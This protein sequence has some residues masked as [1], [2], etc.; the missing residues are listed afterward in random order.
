MPARLI[1]SCARGKS[2]ELTLWQ[3][4]G[5]D[6]LL[7]LLVVLREHNLG[8]DDR[9]QEG[10]N[11]HPDGR[12]HPGRLVDRKNAERLGIVRFECFNEEL[13]KRPVHVLQAEIGEIEHETGLV[14]WRREEEAAG[15]HAEDGEVAQ[16][17]EGLLFGVVD[18]DVDVEDWSAF[19]IGTVEVGLARLHLKVEAWKVF[20]QPLFALLNDAVNV[21][22]DTPCD[23][24]RE[25]AKCYA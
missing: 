4:L 19:G 2:N 10:L 8:R 11:G 14:R 9:V 21:E 17:L 22:L 15:L 20:I 12:E 25:H 6:D 5:V 7:E 1:S 13:D 16:G 23:H 24:A 3:L 18:L